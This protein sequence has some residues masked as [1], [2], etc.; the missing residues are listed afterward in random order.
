L[1]RAELRLFLVSCAIR[2]SSIQEGQL[3]MAD[4]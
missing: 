1:G 3:V 2:S 4:V